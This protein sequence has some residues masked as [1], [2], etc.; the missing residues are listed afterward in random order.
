[1]SAHG[2]VGAVLIIVM[3]KLGN[4]LL[5]V[6]HLP[7]DGR[8][9]KAGR[10]LQLRT[11]EVVYRKQLRPVLQTGAF[12]MDGIFSAGRLKQA[13]G[14]VVSESDCVSDTFETLSQKP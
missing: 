5:A 6:E 7:R 2:A 3:G 4:T 8:D 10:T 1:V 14:P 13:I 12:V 11:T 9:R